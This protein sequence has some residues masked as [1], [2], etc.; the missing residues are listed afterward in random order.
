VGALLCLVLGEDACREEV[1]DRHRSLVRAVQDGARD[2]AREL[3]ER[4]VQESTA[5]LIALRVTL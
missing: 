4:C 1:A 2:A 5:R 3:A